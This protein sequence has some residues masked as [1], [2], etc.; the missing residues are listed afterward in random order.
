MRS[1]H[2]FF[3]FLTRR[4]P[5]LATCP[6]LLSQPAQ[7][8]WVNKVLKV[9]KVH[10]IW[11]QTGLGT[12]PMGSKVLLSIK[13]CHSTA[14]S[15]I[16]SPCSSILLL[17]TLVH[18]DRLGSAQPVDQLAELKSMKA[19]VEELQAERKSEQRWHLLEGVPHFPTFHL[20]CLLQCWVNVW[21]Q[22]NSSWRGSKVRENYPLWIFYR[23]ILL[24]S[25]FFFYVLWLYSLI[26]LR[27]LMVYFD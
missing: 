20:P 2:L 6:K 17:L 14:S 23:F 25:T 3:F 24:E 18:L 22:Q 7:A 15:L 5:D 27:C 19:A 10:I 26:I 13:S 1:V 9:N 21:V 11:R 16:M 8:I 12:E 4:C